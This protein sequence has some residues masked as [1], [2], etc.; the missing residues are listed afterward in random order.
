MQP[1]PRP[2]QGEWS[3]ETWAERT[4]LG[5]VL[6]TKLLNTPLTKEHK[7]NYV[8]A[9]VQ[10]QAQAVCKAE[11]VQGRLCGSELAGTIPTAAGTGGSCLQEPPRPGSGICRLG[12]APC[13]CWPPS[14]CLSPAQGYQPLTPLASALC[15]TVQDLAAAFAF[16]SPKDVSLCRKQL[17]G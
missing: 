8:E 10:S 14:G 13:C 2:A 17:L 3:K 5:Q 9:L 7:I 4:N 12:A 15:N 6:V 16:S 1:H 11:P